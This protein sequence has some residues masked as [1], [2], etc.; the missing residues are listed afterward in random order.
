MRDN[1][2]KLFIENLILPIDY[3]FINNNT[4]E[5][6]FKMTDK[7]WYFKINFIV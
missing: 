6:Y 4:I 1:K 5:K 2:H 7:K 3:A